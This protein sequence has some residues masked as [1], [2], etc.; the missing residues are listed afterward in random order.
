MQ[1][2]SL[3]A[4]FAASTSIAALAL[5]GCGRG[6]TAPQT[7]TPTTTGTSLPSGYERFGNGVQVHVEGSFVVVES[8]GVPDHKSPYFATGDARYE[9]YNG[10]NPSFIRAPGS[11]VAQSY[12]FRSPLSPSVP[13]THAATPL[14]PIGVSLNGVPFFNQYN[15]QR[16][17]LTGEI[18]SFDQYDGH[19]TPM[20]QY[21]YHV[22]PLSLT[23]REGRSA[24]LGFLLDGF[25]VYGPE[26]GGRAV[27]NADLDAFHGHIG[28]TA[29]Y[30]NGIYH[31]H[32]TA[33]APYIN[34]AGFYGTPG[35]VSQ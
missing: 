16:Q 13:A 19:P 4:G 17:P 27:T 12:T 24:L 3:L 23:A 33:E 6:P 26:E 8:N 22:E 32:V 2:K 9:A 25:P 11:I 28:A 20:N 31:Y 18:N 14:G 21:H 35:T 5:A 29:E 30:P 1:K 10:A 15:G 34:G 7:S